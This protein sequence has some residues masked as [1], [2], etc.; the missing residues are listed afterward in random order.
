MTVL[1]TPDPSN[2]LFSMARRQFKH[3]SV[4]DISLKGSKVAWVYFGCS[5]MRGGPCIYL[6]L[7]SVNSSFSNQIGFKSLETT[8][9]TF[10]YND[11][12]L[13]P[14]LSILALLLRTMVLHPR[15]RLWH[16]QSHQDSEGVSS[17]LWRR[18]FRHGLHV[19]QGQH[20]LERLPG[21]YGKYCNKQ[22]NFVP[23]T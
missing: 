17:R 7:L 11:V 16:H 6:K 5:L 18:L 4:R 13:Y 2:D 22:I 12:V 8:Y 21:Y 10:N 23:N 9:S 1:I 3:T 15:R 20:Q 19:H 14:A